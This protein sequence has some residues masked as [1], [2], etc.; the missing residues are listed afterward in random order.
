MAFT[1]KF[2][3][4]CGI[5]GKPFEI[6]AII[7]R[8]KHIFHQTDRSSAWGHETCPSKERAS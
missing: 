1:T 3:G 6:G 2:S 4:T 5:C 8:I 7:K